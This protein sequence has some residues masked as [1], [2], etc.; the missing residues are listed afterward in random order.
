M[1]VL[2][3]ASARRDRVVGHSAAAGIHPEPGDTRIAIT[4][5]CQPGP[6]PVSFLLAFDD[7][8]GEL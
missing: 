6:S 3:S 8:A 2:A 1:T 4:D 7:A 5:W